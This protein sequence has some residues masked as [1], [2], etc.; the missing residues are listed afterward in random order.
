MLSRFVETEPS[1]AEFCSTRFGR[2]ADDGRMPHILGFDAQPSL[3]TADNRPIFVSD[4]RHE[5]APSSSG[6]PFLR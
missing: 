2:S 3:M 6:S 4:T 5:T 1:P